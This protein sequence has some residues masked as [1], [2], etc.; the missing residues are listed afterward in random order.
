MYLRPHV[1]D[2]VLLFRVR[3]ILD[4]FYLVEVNENL[5]D[6]TYWF[7]TNNSCEKKFR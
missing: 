7:F 6:A 2:D 1:A 5:I 4:L 3:R